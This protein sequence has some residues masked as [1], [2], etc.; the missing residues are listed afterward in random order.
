MSIVKAGIFIGVSSSMAS[1]LTFSLGREYSYYVSET[2]GA[3]QL[4][5]NVMIR[6]A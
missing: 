2:A 4:V 5:L 3:N 1:D 6:M